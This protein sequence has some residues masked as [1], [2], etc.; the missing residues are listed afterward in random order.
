MRLYRSLPLQ[1]LYEPTYCGA[2]EVNGKVNMAMISP[3]E[4]EEEEEEEGCFFLQNNLLLVSAVSTATHKFLQTLQNLS[5]IEV[6]VDW[7]KL[8]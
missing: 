1:Q 5:A 4:E 2:A 8:V 6:C 7:L 3:T